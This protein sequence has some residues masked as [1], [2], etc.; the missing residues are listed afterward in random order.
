MTSPELGMAVSFGDFASI[1]SAGSLSVGGARAPRDQGLGAAGL[2]ISHPNS[3]SKAQMGNVEGGL[4][5]YVGSCHMA[6]ETY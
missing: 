1:P 3:L 5:S 2:L 4:T 6:S